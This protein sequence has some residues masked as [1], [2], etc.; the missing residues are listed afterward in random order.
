MSG[1]LNDVPTLPPGIRP[2]WYCGSCGPDV[3]HVLPH[4]AQPQH[5][6]PQH[7]PPF[8]ED[9]LP[10]SQQQQ[11]M[12]AQYQVQQ[13]PVQQFPVQMAAPAI[14][15]GVV[16]WPYRCARPLFNPWKHR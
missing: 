9:V 14:Q 5:P 3:C 12:W 7:P 1:G 15:P 2:V 11:A 8:I 4:M 16:S 13:Y 6:P 10:D